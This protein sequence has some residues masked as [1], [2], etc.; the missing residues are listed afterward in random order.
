MRTYF[1]NSDS[2]S[3]F[4]ILHSPLDNLHHDHTWPTWARL[5]APII[6]QETHFT[7][8]CGID[9]LVVVL[10]VQNHKPHSLSQSSTQHSTTCT[11]T[12]HRQLEL[13]SVT[14]L[15]FIKTSS[16]WYEITSADQHRFV[17]LIVSIFLDLR[18]N[19]V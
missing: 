6:I 14:I 9:L 13:D 17:S 12:T 4:T 2:R 5:P 3:T 8:L 1:S 15:V 16:F 7:T 11:M 10:A 19:L 18:F